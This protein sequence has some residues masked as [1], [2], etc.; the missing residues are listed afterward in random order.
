MSKQSPAL[1]E[2][3]AR[4]FEEFQFLV[5]AFGF[6]GEPVPKGYNEFGVW[7]VS[8]TT[9]IV[10][11]GIHWGT[12]A[13][14]AFGSAGR[15][16]DFEDCDLIDFLNLRYPDEMPNEAEMK[17]GQHHQLGLFAA[18]LRRHAEEILKGDLSVVA[19]ILEIQ[20]RRAEEWEQED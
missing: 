11:E 8:D 5:E 9:R 18:L 14:V 13:R 1:N 10:V 3:R 15:P 2:F 17:R 4:A 12:N 6:R 7:F 20:R 16:E 19:E